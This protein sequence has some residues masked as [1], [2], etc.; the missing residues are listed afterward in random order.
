MWIATHWYTKDRERE[1]TQKGKVICLNRYKT[2][3]VVFSTVNAF[4]SGCLHV[5]MKVN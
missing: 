2:C 1:R 4:L 3:E 5:S